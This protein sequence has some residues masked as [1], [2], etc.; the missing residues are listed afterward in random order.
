MG[1]DSPAV[2]SRD[3][4]PFLP[5]ISEVPFFCL[6]WWDGGGSSA[7]CAAAGWCICHR[8]GIEW[9][10][11]PISSSGSLILL[12]LSTSSLS[13]ATM[14]NRSSACSHF[15][16]LLSLLSSSSSARRW[17]SL[18]PETWT[19]FCFCGNLV[20][21][22]ASFPV[23]AEDITPCQVGTIDELLSRDWWPPAQPFF[24]AGGWPHPPCL[25]LLCEL[26]CPLLQGV[27]IEDGIIK[28]SKRKEVLT[29]YLQ[30]LWKL[31]PGFISVL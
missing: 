17:H 20:C 6:M 13:T 23:T 14:M 22:T 5:P 2:F 19:A 18:L 30:L 9:L 15:T 10:H 31:P 29:F 28:H 1:G 3:L 7:S 4:F 26:L 16:Q 27:G 8:D 21:T 11:Q 24:W 25:P 12:N